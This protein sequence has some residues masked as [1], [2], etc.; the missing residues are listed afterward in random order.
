MAYR[1]TNTQKNEIAKN[2]VDVMVND[3]PITKEAS[4]F[5]GNWILTGPEEK[6][7]GFYDIWDAVLKNYMPP[8][9]PLLFRSC[10]RRNDGKIAS[11]TG[12]LF[13]AER[14]KTSTGFLLICD[15]SEALGFAHLQKSGAYK[16]TFF[17][18]AEL[19]KKV[20]ARPNP[21]FS[22]RLVDDY[23]KEDEYVMRVN[24]GTMCSCKW[25]PD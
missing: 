23:A 14:F 4:A 20:G 6:T 22:R 13:C 11:F 1:W 25:Y 17:P 9:R 18:V 24:L 12:R 3:A 2:L 5:I 8:G 19:L 7:K 10:S 15:T 21:M 16:H